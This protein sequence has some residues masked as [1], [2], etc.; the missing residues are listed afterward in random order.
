MAADAQ[1]R[2]RQQRAGSLPGANRTDTWVDAAAVA[3]SAVPVIHTYDLCALCSPVL[4]VSPVSRRSGGFITTRGFITKA[5]P[6]PESLATR[7]K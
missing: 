2:W 1:R 3:S 6:T 7:S 5:L 4:P